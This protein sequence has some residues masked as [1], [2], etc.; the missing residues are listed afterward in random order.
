MLNLIF[1]TSN[2]LLLAFCS[3][4]LAIL[5][6]ITVTDVFGRYILG[7]PL[8]G[9][10][11]I[12]EITLGILIYLGLPYISRNEEHISVSLLSTYLSK[13]FNIIHK[14]LINLIISIV[15][16]IITRQLYMHGIDLK[17]Y[18]EVNIFLEIPKYPIAFT[19]ALLTLLASFT[20]ILNIFEYIF[21]KNNLTSNKQSN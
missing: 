17:S 18:Q 2:K 21:I 16:L 11:E 1:Q 7:I 4:S 20:N 13:K 5:V 14:V 10:T 6:F 3:L 12:T 9:T 19:M 15:L 8:S